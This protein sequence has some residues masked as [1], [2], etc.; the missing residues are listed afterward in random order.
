MTKI[1]LTWNKK[2][3][4]G[5][6]IDTSNP[7][8]AF[9]QLQKTIC[10]LTSVEPANQKIFF[11]RR[12]LRS[13]ADLTAAGGLTENAT[14]ML[15]G[16]ATA[17]LKAMADAA[18]SAAARAP[19]QSDSMD[20]AADIPSGPH[21]LKNIGNTCYLNATIQSLRLVPELRDELRNAMV[22]PGAS[23]RFPVAHQLHGILSAQPG[24]DSNVK[25]DPLVQALR[26]AHPQFAQVASGGGPSSGGKWD[27]SSMANLSTQ[28][29]AAALM[30]PQ[31]I[32]QDAQECWSALVQDADRATGNASAVSRLFNIVTT[33][34]RGDPQDPAAPPSLSHDEASMLG[35]HITEE[36]NSLEDS[37]RAG[38]ASTAASRDQPSAA[39]EPG[40]AGV[41]SPPKTTALFSRLPRYLCVHFAR[42]YW[43]QE[44]NM[45]TKILRKVT[46]PL[47][48]DLHMLCTEELRERQS[49]VRRFRDQK[50]ESSMGLA[51]VR[52]A[53]EA[54]ADKAADSDTPMATS[55][56]EGED[57]QQDAASATEPIF[58]DEHGTPDPYA[59]PTG[60]YE[61]KAVVA[62]TGRFADQG[63]YIAYV[64]LPELQSNG[65]P[66]D[67]KTRRRGPS[68]MGSK[69]DGWW[70]C[71]DDTIRP[72]DP[73]EIARL[74]GGGDWPIAYLCLYAA[75]EDA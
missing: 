31:Y 36:I 33:I 28:D 18:S 45:K 26:R 42:F 37:I 50:S 51:P 74:D 17:T 68:L 11:A 23:G 43:K 39:T 27:A 40:P 10:D 52:L 57:A 53:G 69:G 22:T 14:V 12:M 44:A 73:N 16:T 65:G 30:P 2:N 64:R 1:N 61:L 58:L 60:R 24:S 71:D 72:A 67:A 41:A 13:G 66:N 15:V 32:H 63:H 25:P 47:H 35:C 3:F 62:H 6:E 5:V 9:E 54:P 70:R 75:R 7:D 4:P 56:R 8:Q 38:L 21:P 20:V 55:P 49:V 59:C 46:F 48:L 19:E 29:L 34:S